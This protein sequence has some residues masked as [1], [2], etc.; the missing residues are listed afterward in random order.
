MGLFLYSFEMLQKPK[1]NSG[2]SR[3]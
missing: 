3:N 1:G 2:E